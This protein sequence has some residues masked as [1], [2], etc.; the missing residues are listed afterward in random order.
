MNKYTVIFI[1]SVI[2]F[3][4]IL[5]SDENT[6][7]I[8]SGTRNGG[9]NSEQSGSRGIADF[10]WSPIELLSEPSTGQDFNVG[11]SS[12]AD[13]AVEGDKIYVVWPDTNNTNGAGTDFDIFF[14]YFNGGYWSD[15]QVISE[16]VPGQNLSSGDGPKI[17]VENGKIYVVWISSNDTNGAGIDEDIFYRTNLTGAGWEP[18][19]VLSEPIAGQNFNVRGCSGSSSIAVENGKVYVLW[20]DFN[21]TYGSGTDS[22]INFRSNLSG[23]GW[24]DIQVISEPIVGDN[25]NIENSGTGRNDIVVEN[26]K[27]YTVWSDW[28]DT[29]GAGDGEN[30]IFYRANL[31]G[32]S[33]DPVQVISEPVVG[34]N[35]NTDYSGPPKIAVENSK[36][37]VVW[38]DGTII[39]GAGTD[40][41]VF[42]RTNLTGTGWEPIQV[43]SEPVLGNNFNTGDTT[44]PYI[45]VEDGTI[46][47]TW[48]DRNETDGAGTDW[49][50]FY[51][52][53]STGSNWSPVQVISE[54]LQGQDSNIGR[55]FKSS[56]LVENNK[57]YV[58]WQDNNNTN[59]AGPDYD[60]F[61]RMYPFSLGPKIVY[62][63]K[64]FSDDS[65]SNPIDVAEIGDIVYVELCGLDEVP[66]QID[67]AAVDVKTYANSNDMIRVYAVETGLNTGIFHGSF[68]ISSQT[69][70]NQKLI[71]SSIGDN[72]T[73]SSVNDPS[74]YTKVL[75]ST[76]V[77]IRPLLDK[78]T[79]IEDEEYFMHYWYFGY[80]TVSAWTFET[81]AQWLNWD[82]TDHN[83]YGTPENGDVGTSWVRLNIT[84]GL[85]NYDEHYF[86]ID[87]N[88]TIPNITNEDVAAAIEDKLY[89]VDYNSSDDSSGLVT[90]HLDFN[91]SWLKIDSSTGEL[92]GTPGSDDVGFFQVN[93]S[94]NDG[95]GG[96]NWSVFILKVNDVPAITTDDVTIAI[97]DEYYYVDYNALDYDDSGNIKWN[98]VT[99][100]EW[101]GF[102]KDSGELNGTPENEHVGSY[103]VNVSVIDPM[104]NFNNHN[105]TLEVMNVNDRPEWVNVPQDTEINEN[106][107]FR[108]NINATDV[109]IGD[110]LTYNIES[111]P[112]SDIKIDSKT[113][114]IEWTPLLYEPE[115]SQEIFEI[116]VSVTDGEV[117]IKTNFNLLV[118]ANIRP[119][120]QIL[121]PEDK[122][123]VSSRG[124]ELKWLG[125]DTQI[126]PLSYDVYFSTERE[127]V[128]SHQ[129]S[130]KVITNT[131]NPSYFIEDLFE[132]GIY[133]LTVIPFDGLNY[134]E[135]LDG[136]ITIYVNSPPAFP[137]ISNQK[138]T[139]NIKFQ[140]D[141]NANDP[142]IKDMTSLIYSLETAPD[143]MSIEPG[144]GIITWNPTKD[145][146]GKH[147]VKVIVSDGLDTVNTTFEIEV[148]ENEVE[149]KLS[150]QVI[151]TISGFTILI[152]IISFFIA[153]TEVGKYKF[154]AV[155][156]VPL[157]NRLHPDKIFDN[158]TRNQIHGY[159]NNKP[160][161]HFSAIKNA[162]KLNTGTLLYHSRILE[163]EGYIKS[164]RDKLYTRFYPTGMNAQE[165]D[166]YRPS[167]IQKKL[168][169]LIQRQPGINQ[170]E[171][172]SLFNISQ[173]VISY[174][175]NRLIRENIIRVE[176]EGRVKKYFFNYIEQPSQQL[177]GPA[178]DQVYAFHPAQTQQ[179]YGAVPSGGATAGPYD[180]PKLGSGTSEP[181]PEPK[182]DN[183]NR[184]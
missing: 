102:N 168:I 127:H 63:V 88:N 124:T 21:D 68:K 47:V 73:I 160:G 96:W 120:V 138:A 156:V 85:G 4:F 144:T 75:V 174:N 125:L 11:E 107:L 8:H 26:G 16:P 7:A 45:V 89:Y 30:D 31:T 162:L 175:L 161:E 5:I 64:A 181:Q 66:T 141:M 76:P 166:E 9:V 77:Q 10:E 130:V 158:N 157:Y 54:P 184:K 12:W 43:I 1:V 15:V 147:T 118:N 13:I 17:T 152:L 72:I 148:F 153:G 61:F 62:W 165:I 167:D 142:N 71:K 93:V 38:T 170:R 123:Y 178:Q 137:D 105:F 100:A 25:F 113:G 116:E 82:G 52:Y 83:I 172:S 101:L 59:G 53:N 42:Y 119:T 143:G 159:I 90:W 46:Y 121:A 108:L 133:F 91:A 78:I 99:T 164:K 22:D 163:K 74:K 70:Q 136:I 176:K 154:L 177:P 106:E 80:N 34:S 81:G 14:K 2:L 139:E 150:R 3:N 146:V 67:R 171:I 134:G 140:I 92:S 19:Q 32:T 50:I 60:I 39:N 117:T 6:L 65:Y 169:D 111:I 183:G 180:D 35:T 110:V 18:I 109:D 129:E 114:M 132:G 126:E 98:L 33:W 44:R 94:V 55:S 84:D 51:R 86:T 29:Y 131:Y 57:T 95:N 56:I 58:I 23:N 128:V 151:I 37:Y 173:S 145:Q 40:R 179:Q 122:G 115:S 49:D 28:N 112:S 87:V 24:E 149:N 27:I 69:N 104:G 79:A 41:D 155:S 97:E 36:L 20:S 182:Y 103:Y 48:E 135:C